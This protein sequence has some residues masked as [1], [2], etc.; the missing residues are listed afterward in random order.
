MAQS[1]PDEVPVDLRDDGLEI[2]RWEDRHVDFFLAGKP[3]DRRILTVWLILFGLA[4]LFVLLSPFFGG[5]VITAVLWL[6]IFFG[7]WGVVKEERFHSRPVRIVIDGDTV[8]VERFYRKT[9]RTSE[10]AFDDDVTIEVIYKELGRTNNTPVHSHLELHGT[11]WTIP[12][13]YYLNVKTRHALARHLSQKLALGFLNTCP[14]CETELLPSQIDAPTGC[15]SCVAC[16]W[17]SKPARSPLIKSGSGVLLPRVPSR[18]IRI[19]ENASGLLTI[20]WGP[21]ST[22]FGISP[23]AIV[24]G[25]LVLGFLLFLSMIAVDPGP[26][27]AES[28]FRWTLF[29]VCG[30]AALMFAYWLHHYYQRTKIKLNHDFNRVTVEEGTVG[31]ARV[32]QFDLS[33]GSFFSWNDPR[34]PIL[35][36]RL[37]LLTHVG[38]VYLATGDASP[39]EIAG[40]KDERQRRWFVTIANRFMGT[41]QYSL[42]TGEPY[43]DQ[44]PACEQPLRPTGIDLRTGIIYCAAAPNCSWNS[45]HGDERVLIAQS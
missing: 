18:R 23:S 29:S 22:L 10:Y 41:P 4:T 38:A 13:G 25:V 7:G 15:Q 36:P 34:R 43:P 16:K 14:V 39:V 33:P 1:S 27:V 26:P 19:E 21:N 28:V 44:C 31:F 12:F 30:V 35:D 37:T 6:I 20:S 9:P 42:R 17:T 8:R 24:V 11:D 40:L 2:H 3:A 5:F 32:R 45:Y